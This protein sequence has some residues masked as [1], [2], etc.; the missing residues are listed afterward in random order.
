MNV[1]ITGGTGFIGSRLALRCLAKGDHVRVLGRTANPAEA[2]NL[3]LIEK[4]GAEVVIGE[5]TDKT[6]LFGLTRN[7]HVVYH[8]AA[9]QHEANAP[10]KVFHEVN[11]IGTENLL[12]ASLKA[13]VKRF[14][15]GSTIGVYGT[16]R[17]VINE[18]S[19][20][21][22]DNI[23]GITKLNGEKVVLSYR[24]KIGVVVIR[25][26]E[27]YGPGDRRLLKLFKTI[28]KRV[29]FMIGS[30]ENLHHLIYIDDLIDGLLLSA[31]SKKAQGNIFILA[32]EKPITTNEM[33]H[34]I[35]EELDAGIPKIRAPLFLFLLMATVMEAIL[36]PLG[37][38]P[39]LHRRRMDFFRK[40]FCLS[41]RKAFDFFGFVPKMSFKKGVSETARWYREA[42]D[43]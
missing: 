21:H 34:I 31:E 43:L 36:K 4:S 13:G 12:E 20:C 5:I 11:V 18:E 29:F 10:D 1:L 28:D 16:L 35:A 3:Q 14:V 39:P 17:G 33:V 27:T 19:P 40:N 22:P 23:Y 8:L 25:I 38:Q 2:S 30:G 9:A 26:S 42:D 7:I 6:I 24:D 41:H 32:G 37:I 15:H